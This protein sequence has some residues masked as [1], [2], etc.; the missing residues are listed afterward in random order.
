VVGRSERREWIGHEQSLGNATAQFLRL[1]L[2]N[3]G[4]TE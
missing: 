1:C 2:Q 4:N 3:A